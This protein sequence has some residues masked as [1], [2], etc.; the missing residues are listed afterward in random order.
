[1]TGSAKL[2][3]WPFAEV[4][5][6]IAITRPC[7]LKTGPPLLPGFASG[8]RAAIANVCRLAPMVPLHRAQI[9]PKGLAQRESE[10]HRMVC[11]LCRADSRR[12]D[13]R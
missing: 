3:Y 7:E 8:E 9:G 4:A 6:E 11:A 5:V 13:A 12:C 2:R 1:M 10:R